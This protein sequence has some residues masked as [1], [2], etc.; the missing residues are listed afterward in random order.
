MSHKI[1]ALKCGKE[2]R[3]I[4]LELQK[5]CARN[6]KHVECEDQSDNNTSNYWSNWKWC[7]ILGYRD[8]DYE[9]G[10]SWSDEARITSHRNVANIYKALWR[11]FPEGNILQLKIR[12]AF[13]SLKALVMC[14]GKAQSLFLSVA[15][16]KI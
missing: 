2:G 3:R 12:P 1:I 14:K 5:Y 6:A 8:S 4:G 15:S 7:N 11:R 10:Q 9:D 13:K 16:D